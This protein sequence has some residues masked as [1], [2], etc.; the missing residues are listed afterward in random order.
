MRTA[1]NTEYSTHFFS[2]LQGLPV[3][4]AGTD[5]VFGK[6]T[7]LIGRP[8]ETYLEITKLVV[9]PKAGGPEVAIDLRQLAEFA[10]PRIFLPTGEE[11]YPAMAPGSSEIRLTRE[12]LDHQIVDTAGV[13]VY[14]V[15]DISIMLTEGKAILGHVDVGFSGLL[16]R[17]GFEKPVAWFASWALGIKMRDRFISWRFVQ[18][19][20]DM[21]GG[22]LALKLAMPFRRLAN[23][24]P[25]DLARILEELDG[26]EREIFFYLMDHETAAEVLEVAEP[27]VQRQIIKGIDTDRAADVL[28]KMSPAEVTDILGDLPASDA[29]ELLKEME[30]E[31]ADDVRELLKHDKEE[32]GGLM[33]TAFA[34]F[35]PETTAGEVMARLKGIAEECDVVSYFYVVGAENKLLGVVN[36]RKLIL[37][38]SDAALK[39]IMSTHMVTAQ[40]DTDKDDIARMFAK[41]G[42]RAIPVVNEKGSIVGVIRFKDLVEAVAPE[43]G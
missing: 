16:R 28:E 33:T 8:A 9:S 37:S 36:M 32:G 43:L 14:R 38:D 7:D 19:L 6:L 22:K 39:D 1:G 15:N 27:E 4:Y 2:H 31:A 41:Y 20:P 30:P 13:R 42:L 40:T 35:S 34:S 11:R 23:L 18:T 3:R 29:A 21:T 17:L 26:S 5:R 10:P 12:I 25:V 24:H